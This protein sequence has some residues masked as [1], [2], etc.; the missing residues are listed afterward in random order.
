M[1]ETLNTLIIS[2][3][4]YMDWLK[5]RY[6]ATPDN[7]MMLEKCVYLDLCMKTH[8]AFSSNLGKGP[9]AKIGKSDQLNIKIGR[10]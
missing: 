4:F 8:R 1:W 7:F 2:N 3:F 6:L 5:Y 9:L 10:N